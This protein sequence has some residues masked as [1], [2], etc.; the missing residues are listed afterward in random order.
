MKFVNPIDRQEPTALKNIYIVFIYY[1][2]KI[3]G[4]YAAYRI[5]EDTSHVTRCEDINEL[6]ILEE[7]FIPMENLFEME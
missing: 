3:T 2:F 7:I 1:S 4:K 6:N 5:I